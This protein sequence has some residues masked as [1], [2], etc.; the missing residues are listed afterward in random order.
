MKTIKDQRREREDNDLSES[1]MSSSLDPFSKE[2][3]SVIS[4]R[5]IKRKI[6]KTKM[7]KANDAH[8]GQYLEFLNAAM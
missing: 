4:G 6:H 1:S 8:R 2:E 7:D 3:R 5:K